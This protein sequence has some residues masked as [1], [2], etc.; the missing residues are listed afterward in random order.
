MPHYQQSSSEFNQLPTSAPMQVPIQPEGF[1]SAASCPQKPAVCLAY[2][3]QAVQSV[4][5]VPPVQ[6][7][8]AGQPTATIQGPLNTHTTASIQGNNHVLP[9]AQPRS[10]PSTSPRSS[11]AGSSESGIQNSHPHSIANYPDNVYPGPAMVAGPP[12]YVIPSMGIPYAPSLPAYD[13]IL[14]FTTLSFTNV[15]CVD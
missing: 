11:T 3:V 5:H 8:S 6:H 12:A 4:H 7:V 9:H 14:F 1:Y 2:P 15:S 10:A 13:G